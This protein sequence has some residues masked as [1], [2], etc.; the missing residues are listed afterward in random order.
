MAFGKQ[1]GC[2]R[3]HWRNFFARCLAHFLLRPPVSQRLGSRVH[4]VNLRAS[5]V[6]LYGLPLQRSAKMGIGDE[7]DV[8]TMV[9]GH[10]TLSEAFERHV[11]G[12]ALRHSTRSCN[13]LMADKSRLR[14]ASDS[15][16]VESHGRHWKPSASMAKWRRIS[17][18]VS[19]SQI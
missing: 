9:V 6:Q 19:K 2:Q 1:R 13:D 10:T 14:V 4:M 5:N 8:M 12:V 16:A 15:M 18:R 3:Q 17:K 7:W 11:A